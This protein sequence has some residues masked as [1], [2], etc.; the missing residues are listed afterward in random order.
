[1]L[2]ECCPPRVILTTATQAGLVRCAI[3]NNVQNI[4]SARWLS[5][6]PAVSL[7]KTL[8]KHFNPFPR[9]LSTVR[10]PVSLRLH[11]KTADHPDRLQHVV[12]ASSLTYK[13][14]FTQTEWKPLCSHPSHSQRAVVHSPH[15]T[16]M[17]LH[18]RQPLFDTSRATF[19]TD[20]IR[21]AKKADHPTWLTSGSER[22]SFTAHIFPLP[23]PCNRRPTKPEAPSAA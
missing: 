13:Y 10:T 19:T 16:R 20:C 15:Q 5:E 2:S 3:K 6:H 17:D 12:D 8:P 9:D 21:S 22:V 14:A 18:P 11:S 4:T 23:S 7:R 1:M